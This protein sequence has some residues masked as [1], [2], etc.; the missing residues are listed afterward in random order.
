MRYYK[1]SD[2]KYSIIIQANVI[3]EL[4]QLSITLQLLTS[5]VKIMHIA[6]D[7]EVIVFGDP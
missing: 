7:L 6:P 4:Y 2:N 5:Y 3:K 1:S